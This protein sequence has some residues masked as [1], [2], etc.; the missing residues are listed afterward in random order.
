MGGNTAMN[1]RKTCLFAIVAFSVVMA[2]NSFAQGR[3]RGMHGAARLHEQACAMD[4]LRA[5]KN[6]EAKKQSQASETASSEPQ[7]ISTTYTPDSV[8]PTMTVGLGIA[9]RAP[10]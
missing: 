8:E 2:S 9:L 6:V 7:L 10:A 3:D 5:I 4:R 1:V